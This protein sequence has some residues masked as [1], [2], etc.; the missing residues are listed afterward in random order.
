MASTWLGSEEDVNVKIREE[1]EFERMRVKGAAERE[2][3]KIDL[4]EEQWERRE[5]LKEMYAGK[6]MSMIE[7][8]ISLYC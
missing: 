5:R 2:Q 7:G 6:S 1:I 8:S 3:A 4:E